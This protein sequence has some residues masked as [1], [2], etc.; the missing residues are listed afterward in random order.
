MSLSLEYITEFL[1]HLLNIYLKISFKWDKFRTYL[2]KLIVTELAITFANAFT[3][4][5]KKLTDYRL[6]MKTNNIYQTPSM[7]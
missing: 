3:I 4:D 5:K 1:G 6:V 2:F 7:G